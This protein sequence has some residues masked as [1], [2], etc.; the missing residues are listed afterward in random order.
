MRPPLD[1]A[2]VGH[3]LYELCTVGGYCLPRNQ[4]ARL[5]GRPPPDID[6]FADAVMRAEALDPHAEKRRREGV[7]RIIAKHWKD[8]EA[9]A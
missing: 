4:R 3:I 5:Q 7:I 8:D 2:K 9:R 1:P 6:A